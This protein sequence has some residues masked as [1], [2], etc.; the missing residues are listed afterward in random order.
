[1]LTSFAGIGV[2]IAVMVF[3]GAGIQ[4]LNGGTRP[5]WI[6]VAP[7]LAI[8][9]IPAIGFWSTFKFLRCP[10]CEQVVAMQVSWQYS[11]FGDSASKTCN[12]CNAKIFPDDTGRRFTR[13]LIVMVL[14]G[15][16]LGL[17]AAIAGQ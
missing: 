11:P 1:M 3:A 15:A 5:D 13:M 14:V 8:L 17:V 4:A 6:V 12:A 7:I 2:A 9:L 10:A 16:V